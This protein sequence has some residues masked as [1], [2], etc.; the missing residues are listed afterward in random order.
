MGPTVKYA[1]LERLRLTTGAQAQRQLALYRARVI[2]RYRL[3]ARVGKPDEFEMIADPSRGVSLAY[4]CRTVRVRLMDGRRWT[5]VRDFQVSGNPD[6][7]RLY[8]LL[9]HHFNTEE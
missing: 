1:R 8:A 5:E 9:D 3:R 4:G 2:A 7:Q 6:L